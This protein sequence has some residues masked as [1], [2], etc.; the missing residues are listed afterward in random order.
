MDSAQVV[1]LRPNVSSTVKD[2]GLLVTGGRLE[3][4]CFT[5]FQSYLSSVKEIFH[6]RKRLIVL[7]FI[8]VRRESGLLPSLGRVYFLFSKIFVS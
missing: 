5:F 6:A 1:A 8:Q 2:S 3:V 7:C 4:I